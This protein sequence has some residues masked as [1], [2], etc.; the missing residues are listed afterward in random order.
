MSGEITFEDITKDANTRINIKCGKKNVTIPRYA[1][2]DIFLPS[3]DDT[4]AK[5]FL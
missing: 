2:T 3:M 5:F 4:E 1:N